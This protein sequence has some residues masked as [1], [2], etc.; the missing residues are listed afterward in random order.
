MDTKLKKS[1]IIISY[2]WLFLGI[3]SLILPFM[4]LNSLPLYS[5]EYL[6][7]DD[8]QESQEF[9]NHISD[10]LQTFIMMALDETHEGASYSSYGYVEKNTSAT[11]PYEYDATTSTQHIDSYNYVVHEVASDNVVF[12]INWDKSVE[13]TNLNRDKNLLYA[14]FKNGKLLY[15][16][17]Q[18]TSVNLLTDTL[19]SKEYNFFLHFDGEKVLIN[20]DGIEIDVYKDG[21]Y[22]IDSDWFV[23]GYE[24]FET[25]YSIKDITVYM[26][27]V[28][29]PVSY[30]KFGY[31]TDSNNYYQSALYRITQQMTN[32]QFYWKVTF[33]LIIT[34]I[35]IWIIC[36]VTRKNRK[37]GNRLIAEF[38]G[39]IIFELKIILDIV[40]FLLITSFCVNICECLGLYLDF[41]LVLSLLFASSICL[42]LLVNDFKHN[43]NVLKN[44]VCYKIYLSARDKELALPLSKKIVHRFRFFIYLWI[45]AI[46]ALFFFM[47]IMVAEFY[48]VGLL[49]DII[50]FIVAAFISWIFIGILKEN[51]QLA[52]DLEIVEEKVN[53]IH[54]GEFNETLELPTDSDLCVISEKLDDIQNGMKT[55]IDEQLKSERMK[56]ELIT[57]VSHDLKTPLTSII[58]YI[59]LLKNEEELPDY[60]KDYVKILN[61]KA[62]RLNVMVQDIFTVSKAV[63]GE[64]PV[65]LETIDFA[66]LIRQTL[67]DM[68][69]QIEASNV[70][71]KTTL[72][73]TSIMINADGE[74]MYRVFQNLIQNALKY[75]LE[76]SR[77]YISLTCDDVSAIASIKNT[78]AKE[79]DDTVD[80]TERFVR[81]DLSRTDGGSG[82]GLSI[83]KS[84]TE[85][86]GGKFQLTT[87]ADLFVVTVTFPIIK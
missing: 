10:R 53:A 38:T 30:S 56:V 58:S 23:P 81:G 31:L 6:F 8:Y 15:S 1:K 2:V 27:A 19:P 7:T 84:F 11:M 80:F 72:P 75:S 63:S 69:E 22:D 70:I 37:E 26:A 68:S 76:G 79:L 41:Y 3:F 33:I 64:L 28:K 14:V 44:S 54:K 16:N 47:S 65:N 82:L 74:R 34:S 67:A 77:I 25:N 45:T 87:N 51:K 5:I 66:K 50:V 36:I 43:R 62:N 29:T 71:I 21:Y 83:A 86:C 17:Y 52:Y 20:K 40:L 48:E 55:A 24:N 61:E 13:M 18:D 9:K 42:F 46:I 49:F 32:Y 4:L 60:A 59:E 12:D 78:S 35:I 85:N 57:N 39:K 73:D